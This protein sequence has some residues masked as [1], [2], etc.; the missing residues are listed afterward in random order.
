MVSVVENR[1]ERKPNGNQSIFSKMGLESSLRFNNL[2]IKKG[3]QLKI[4]NIIKF[5][6]LVSCSLDTKITIMVLTKINVILKLEKLTH[7]I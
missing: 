6:N 5:L 2:S 7:D 4:V 1:I 3:W